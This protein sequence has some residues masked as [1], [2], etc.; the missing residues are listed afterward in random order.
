[1][2]RRVA[3]GLTKAVLVGAD[4][5]ADLDGGV[6]RRHPVRPGQATSSQ[7]RRERPAGGGDGLDTLR[8]GES[9]DSLAGGAGDDLLEGEAG[10]DTLTGGE[11]A[12]R[13]RFGGSGADPDLIADFTQG[14]DLIELVAAGFGLFGGQPLVL[15]VQSGNDRIDSTPQFILDTDT[16]ILWFDMDGTNGLQPDQ[17]AIF[18]VLPALT[19]AD[20]AVV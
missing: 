12:D 8:G 4:G 2:A 10:L 1:M 9:A 15:R 20:F 17:V 5:R 3:R 16:G 13:F 6:G 18:A 7:L 11:G 19:T 14:E